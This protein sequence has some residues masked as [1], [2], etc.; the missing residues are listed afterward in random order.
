MTAASGGR[1]CRR[2]LNSHVGVQLEVAGPVAQSKVVLGQ[3]G[4]G[5]VEG[6]LVSGQPALVAQHGGGEDDGALEVDVA[7]QVHV[8]AL[9]ARLQLPTFLPGK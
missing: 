5:G 1:R 3:L 8:V 6:H 9:V 2:D 4:L 7:A